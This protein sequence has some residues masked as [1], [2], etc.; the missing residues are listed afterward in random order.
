MSHVCSAA[1]QL[2]K[3]VRYISSLYINYKLNVEV[4]H[5]RLTWTPLRFD[6]CAQRSLAQSLDRV[7]FLLLGLG[8][9]HNFASIKAMT[10]RLK[11]WIVRPK[12]SPLRFAHRVMASYDVRVKLP[13]G[14]HLGSAILDFW[15]LTKLQ[16]SAKIER[17]VTKTNKGTIIC[18]KN[19]KVT[20]RKAVFFI[21]KGIFCFLK[22]LPVNHW[23]PWLHSLTRIKFFPH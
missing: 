11:G 19:I 23:F 16:E 3:N 9:L 6:M 10:V 15:I 1:Q 13:N 14:G 8:P 18:A 2:A 7:F 21:L 22:K 17:K 20:G 12:I 4:V 5:P